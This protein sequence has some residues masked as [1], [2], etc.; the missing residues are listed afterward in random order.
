MFCFLT[1]VFW[2]KPTAYRR[3]P[4]DRHRERADAVGPQRPGQGLPADLA[5]AL[6]ADGGARGPEHPRHRFGQEE[7]RPRLLPVLAQVQDPAHRGRRRSGTFLFVFFFMFAS[8]SSSPRHRPAKRKVDL[9][10][11]F[12]VFDCCSWRSATGG[13]TWATCRARCTSRSSNTRRS[14]SSSSPCA[15]ASRST[16]GPRGPTTSSWPS[17]SATCCCCCCWLRLSFTRVFFAMYN[18]LLLAFSR[19]RSCN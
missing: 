10:E 18:F 16:P 5:P 6:P 14:N 3:E 15:T 11:F 4:V 1:N 17:R 19:P 12:F 13:S 2:N 8:I 7:P 9:T